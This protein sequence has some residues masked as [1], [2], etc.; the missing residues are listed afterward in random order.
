MQENHRYKALSVL[1]DKAKQVGFILFD[2]IMDECSRFDLS[3]QDVDWVSNQIATLNIIVR[4]EMPNAES[5]NDD[6]FDFAQSDYDSVYRRIV[7]INPELYNYIE[8]IKLIVPPQHR[9]FS[10]LKFQ[11]PEGNLFARQRCI[12]MHLRLVLKLALRRY[13]Q[14]GGEIEDYI[15]D[16]MVGL[17][18]A[19]DKYDPYSNG[20]FSSY[21]SRWIMNVIQRQQNTKNPLLYYPVHVKEEYF[22][23]FE[24]EHM[25]DDDFSNPYEKNCIEALL[26]EKYQNGEISMAFMSAFQACDS[27]EYL[28]ETDDEET[29][30]V[31]N[32]LYSY[33][34]DIN[35]EIE[36]RDL[37]RRIANVLSDL[38][39][40]EREIIK[41]RNGFYGNRVYSLE[42]I[43]TK[44]GVTRERIRQ[45]EEKTLRKLRHPSKKEF[46]CEE[47]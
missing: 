42:E 47:T 15:S 35:E 38:N 11:I 24:K 16:G 28:L 12:E 33:E 8:S 40:R 29:W 5:D 13:E 31:N 18:Y 9:E 23:I 27:I 26:Y 21:A 37:Q 17:I 36:F 10:K 20:A 7:E 6:F 44:F 3:I 19:V 22:C 45:I 39:E 30:V 46:L 41:M 4:D 43:G 14:F 25:T 32:R 2:D 1:V 34:N